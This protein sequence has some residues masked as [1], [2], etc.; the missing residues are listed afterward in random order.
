LNRV[1]MTGRITADPKQ[2]TYGDGK[3][4]VSFG[5]AVRRNF[6]NKDGNYDAD[7]FNCVYFGNLSKYISRKGQ[8][9][10][11]A[12]KIE[13]QT[14][15]DKDGNEKKGD[16]ILVESFDLLGPKPEEPKPEPGAY[17][18]PPEISE[19]DLPF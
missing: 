1:E 16:Q 10:G 2:G 17:Q 4:Y 8:L 6:K 7:F 5:I 11:I 14:W 18:E 9:L 13:N 19:D 3:Q 12:G 15:K